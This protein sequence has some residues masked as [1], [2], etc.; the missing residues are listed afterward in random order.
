MKEST[1]AVPTL[2]V[3]PVEPPFHVVLVEPEIPQNTG[4]I[5][6][7][8]V[9][10]CSE[11][12]LVGKLGFQIDEKAVRRAGLDYWRHVKLHRHESLESLGLALPSSRWKLFSAS[13]RRSYLDAVFK[14][15]DT[16]IFGKESVGLPRELLLEHE[17]RTYGIPMSGPIRS[18]NL[19]NAVSIILFEALRQ[20]R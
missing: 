9:G 1:R 12:H 18:F 16:L 2:T 14:P 11:L 20:Q 4:N 5:G 15:G 7:L 3:D 13:A 19:A 6:R 17:E 10:T 8:C